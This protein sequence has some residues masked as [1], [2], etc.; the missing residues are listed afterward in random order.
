[1]WFS[2]TLWSN[3]FICWFPH[4]PSYAYYLENM[5]IMTWDPNHVAGYGPMTGFTVRCTLGELTF[6]GAHLFSAARKTWRG[7]ERPSSFPP[8]LFSPAEKMATPFS[9]VLN[10]VWARDEPGGEGTQN[11]LKVKKLN[12]NKNTKTLLSPPFPPCL[13]SLPLPASPYF[14]FLPLP[15]SV[16][17]SGTTSSTASCFH[18]GAAGEWG[19]FC[20]SCMNR[21]NGWPGCRNHSSNAHHTAMDALVLKQTWAVRQ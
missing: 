11:V 1:M 13:S 18:A 15:C 4:N 16:C 3:T 2:T 21:S 10:T 14:F 9:P 17:A 5:G 8:T 12:K 6:K 7:V 19:P 20:T